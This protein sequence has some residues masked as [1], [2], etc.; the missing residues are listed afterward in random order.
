MTLAGPF[1]LPS[2]PK[3]VY[4]RS[5]SKFE[6][7][8]PSLTLAGPFFSLQALVKVVYYRCIEYI[9]CEGGFNTRQFTSFAF[10]LPYYSQSDTIF[11]GFISLHLFSFE[12]R[13]FSYTL[14]GSLFVASCCS[15]WYSIIRIILYVFSVEGVS[16]N[17]LFFIDEQRCEVLYSW[18]KRVSLL[19]KNSFHSYSS[20]GLV[21]ASL[22]L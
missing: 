19:Y 20:G 11:T 9:V 3:M 16:S 17:L 4:Y 2:L 7:L 13:L 15:K 8:N 6:A 14:A 21:K 12:S 10:L 22:F 1:S 5:V 18:C